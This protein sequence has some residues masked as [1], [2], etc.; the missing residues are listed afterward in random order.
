MVRPCLPPDHPSSSLQ[1]PAPPLASGASVTHCHP[2]AETLLLKA[3]TSHGAPAA[4]PVAQPHSPERPAR[5]AR[6]T[7][8]IPPKAR[9][10]LIRSRMVL[11]TRDIS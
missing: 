9:M 7:T 4:R 1:C 10:F 6:L 2:N 5:T 3:A 8:R 11:A